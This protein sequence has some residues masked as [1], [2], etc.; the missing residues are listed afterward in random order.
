MI[1]YADDFVC[2]FRYK[3]DAERFMKSLK[4]RFN[5]FGLEL[6]EEKTNLIKFSRFSKDRNGSFNFLGFNYKWILSRKGKDI[7]NTTTSK[8]KFKASVQKIK[9]WIKSSRN[10]RLRKLID[11][12]NKKLKGYYNYYGVIGNRKML[13]KMELIVIRL[14]YKWLNRRSQRRSFNWKE[15]SWKI[16]E[17]YPLEEIT[18]EKISVEKQMKIR[19]YA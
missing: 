7:I 16:K 12:L 1:A 13:E 10:L 19:L 11:Q 5:K 8:K 3:R 17:F 15:F 14:L 6:A 9:E 4:K 18:I 2:A